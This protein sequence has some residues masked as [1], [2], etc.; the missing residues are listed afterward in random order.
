MYV[1]QWQG[2]PVISPGTGFPFRRLLWLA[3][4]RWRYSNPPSQGCLRPF[5]MRPI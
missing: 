2:G 5:Y 4:L 1:P 3:G